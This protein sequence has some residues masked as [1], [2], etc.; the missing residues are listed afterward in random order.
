[1]TRE[2]Q[3]KQKSLDVFPIKERDNKKAIGSYDANFQKRKAFEWGAEWAD[4]NP[5]LSEEEQVDMEGLGMVWQKKALIEK[6]C[7]W[8]SLNM[9]DI[10]YFG[11]NGNLYKPEFIQNF[12]RAME[13]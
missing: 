13:E 2:E 6:A 5:N 1:M 12:K 3:I 10:A 11:M 4:A 8:L 9:T 7:M